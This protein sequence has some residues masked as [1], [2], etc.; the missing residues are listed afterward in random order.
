MAGVG[1]YEVGSGKTYATPNLALTALITD[2][3]TDTFTADQEIRVYN[4]TYD[5]FEINTFSQGQLFPN[6]LFHL[7]LKAASG[8]YPVFD[9]ANQKAPITIGGIDYLD[10]EG[11]EGKNGA[12]Y[13]LALGY[14]AVE[15]EKGTHITVK[16]CKFHDIQHRFGILITHC[17]DILI[18]DTECYNSI[19][20]SGI[21]IWDDSNRITIDNCEC[22]HNNNCGIECQTQF[23]SVIVYPTLPTII[24]NHCHHNNG[25][26]IYMAIQT[27]NTVE[28]NICHDSVRGIYHWNYSLIKNNLIYDE[29]TIGICA[30]QNFVGY[31]KIYNNIIFGCNVGIQSV[32]GWE[33]IK[34]KN[35]ILMNNDT[36]IVINSEYYTV[37]CDYNCIYQG[38]GTHFCMH[39]W[40][41]VNQATWQSAGYDAHGIFVDPKF[42][43][44]VNFQIDYNSP[45]IDAGDNSILS[46]VPIDI[47][48]NIRPGVGF[49]SIIDIGCYERS[50]FMNRIPVLENF[51][52]QSPVLDRL[53]APPVSPAP[54]KGSVYIVTPTASGLWATHEKDFALYDGT[55]WIFYTPDEGTVAWVN[56]EATLYIYKSAAW[57]KFFTLVTQTDVPNL[58]AYYKRQT[59][60][61]GD[62]VAGVLGITHDL[63]TSG[64]HPMNV[65][66]FDNNNKQ[67]IP[68]D[69]TGASQL[70]SVDLTS[71]GTLTGTWS[72]IIIG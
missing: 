69:V 34:I 5:V 38:T 66:I 16:N 11:L 3:G 17:D 32:Y 43:D 20:G 35:N 18:Q 8:N 25:T 47:L 55:N 33:D 49:A 24:N 52:W 63:V 62:L 48:G 13:G 61:N 60:T 59:F 29:T 54:V 67:V 68:D 70:L 27:E 39:G 37:D 51:V 41:N 71:F 1:L 23:G 26:D 72:Y 50:K 21:A 19:E 65:V 28:G 64:N 10:I 6:V 58:P 36:S 7:K 9:A 22:H 31:N 30:I 2:Q 56:D 14:G 44:E 53:S 57:V 40:T 4:G 15:G 42:I 46:D 45:C 12:W